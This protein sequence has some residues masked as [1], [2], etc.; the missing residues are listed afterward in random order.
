MYNEDDLLPISALQHLIFCERQCA[1]IHIEQAWSENLF[2]A[3]GRILHDKVHSQT[4][5]SRKNVRT[6]YGMA[7]RSLALGLIGKADVVEFHS[8]EGKWLPF[9]VEYKRGKSKPDNRDT[10]QLCAQAMCLEEMLG[11]LIDQGAIY[12]GKE[13]HRVAIDFNEDLRRETKE[14]VHRLR[15]LIESACTPPPVY[16]VKCDSCSLFEICMPK[17]MEK[18]KSVVDYLA[19]NI[20]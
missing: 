16:E 17:T 18:H 19:E 10:V 12:Y 2:T 11:V 5:E 20:Q 14:T 1:L 3:Q 9:P 6:E 4:S 8:R 7:L 15:C 13:R